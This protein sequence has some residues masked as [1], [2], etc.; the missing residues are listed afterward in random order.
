MA[1]SWGSAPICWASSFP[2]A[3]VFMT[4]SFSVHV[5]SSMIRNLL[6][7]L[8]DNCLQTLGLSLLDIDGLYIAVQLL[9][10]TL[11]VVSLSADTDSKSEWDT[12]DA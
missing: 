8:N 9:L 11:L 1:R 2:L 4:W 6:R 10:C 12:F 3:S 7:V 5:I